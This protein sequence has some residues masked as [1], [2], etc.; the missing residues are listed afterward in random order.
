MQLKNKKLMAREGLIILCLL[1]V[2]GILVFIGGYLFQDT[3]PFVPKWVDSDE[4]ISYG[5]LG[6]KVKL[7]YPDYNDLDNTVLG[8]K[9]QRKIDIL[10][11]LERRGALPEDA[12]ATLK[13]MRA[14]KIVGPRYL[15]SVS[16][17]DSQRRF[18][19][20]RKV[21]DVICIAGLALPLAGYPIRLILWFV[22]WSI[23]TLK[24]R[25]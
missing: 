25:E 18:E 11:E 8:M 7:S 6:K 14:R 3:G 15:G 17:L 19:I 9:T 24:Q 5:D 20:I 4:T 22:F 13:D 12:M 23:K 10:L 2:G 16:Y 21:G 1:L